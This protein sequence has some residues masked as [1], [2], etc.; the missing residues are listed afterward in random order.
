[1]EDATGLGGASFQQYAVALKQLSQLKEQHAAEKQK[2]TLLTQLAT[3][4]S[5]TNPAPQQ[6]ELVQQVQWEA[7]IT[8]QQLAA[9][10]KNKI[11]TQSQSRH[12]STPLLDL[13]C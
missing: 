9:K 2:A 8:H 13:G 11:S 10:V 12:I 5:I 6:S 4:L 7:S 1:M 3:Y